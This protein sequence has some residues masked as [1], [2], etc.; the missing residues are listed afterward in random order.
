[1]PNYPHRPSITADEARARI[2]S[3]C[4]AVSETEQLPIADA[5]GRVLAEDVASPVNVPE[6]NNS[7]MDGYAMRFSD[8]NADGS[9]ALRVAGKSFAGHPFEGELGSGECIRIMTGAVVPASCDTV[10][11]QELSSVDGDTVTFE[12][13][14]RQGDNV[15]LKG[16]ELALGKV[17]LSKGLRLTPPQ[18]GL[19]ATLGIPTVRV[20]RKPVVAILATGDELVQPGTPL[21]DGEIYDSNSFSLEALAKKAGA[22]V[23]RV[24]IVKDSP[25]ALFS[26]L[27]KA[28]TADIVLT[29][30]GVSVGEADFT[31]FVISHSGEIF[32]WEINMRPGR[33]MAVGVISGKPLFCLPGNP[34]AAAVTYLEYA[35]AAI[36]RT[37]GESG[38]LRPVTLTA[39]AEGRF[40]N[41]SAA[42]K[43]SGE[44]SVSMKTASAWSRAP[45]CSPRPCS[46]RSAAE[47]AS[48]GWMQTATL[49]SPG[50]PLRFSPSSAC[51]TSD[52]DSA[53]AGQLPCPTGPG[54]GSR[55]YPERRG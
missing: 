30:G 35:R 2:D 23:I 14:I 15:R 8:L 3:L 16:E 42:M 50:K 51:L 44:F 4:H 33:P 22:D 28:F 40:K 32:D 49:F 53:R 29:S 47:T 26:A 55:L 6:A 17:A 54:R 43:C 52:R 21:K 20:F 46:L 18:I 39:V 25:D 31:R 38:D 48:S 27:E 36:R 9:G 1:M 24:G 19:L 12:A 37:G 10:I 34:V 11:Q 13:G 45:E 7:A 41:A 5:L